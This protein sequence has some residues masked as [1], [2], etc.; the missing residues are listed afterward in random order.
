MTFYLPG[1]GIYES[2]GQKMALKFHEGPSARILN[3]QY[4]GDDID[5]QK[6]KSCEEGILCFCNPGFFIS[7]LFTYNDWH[8]WQITFLLLYL[9]HAKLF[10]RLGSSKTFKRTFTFVDLVS[11]KHSGILKMKRL[12]V[13]SYFQGKNRAFGKSKFLHLTRFDVIMGWMGGW[14]SSVIL[15]SLCKPIHSACYFIIR[16]KEKEKNRLLLS[17]TQLMYWSLIH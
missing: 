14:N 11:C 2:L 15:W 1:I 6:K 7:L 13:F 5:R 8:N 16:A 10:F 4:G 3:N 17:I 12:H 9:L